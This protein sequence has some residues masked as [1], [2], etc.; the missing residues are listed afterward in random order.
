[1]LMYNL[2]KACKVQVMA[3]A[4]GEVHIPPVEVC[5]HTAQQFEN[6]LGR[7]DSQEWPNALRLIAGQQEAYA[8]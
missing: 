2:V 5:E 8:R 7:E 1:M 6:M 3:Q 4:G